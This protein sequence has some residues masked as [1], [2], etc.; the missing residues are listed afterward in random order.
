[1][2]SNEQIVNNAFYKYFKIESVPGSIKINPETFIAELPINITS[3]KKEDVKLNIDEKSLELQDEIEVNIVD[4]SKVLKAN[5]A[6]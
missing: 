6:L 1:M 3:S 5:S 2:K 4:Y